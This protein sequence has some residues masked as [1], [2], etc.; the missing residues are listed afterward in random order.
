MTELTVKENMVASVHYTGTLPDS[1]EV[2]DSSEGREP[3]SFLVGHKQMIPGFEEEIMGAKVGEK[4]EF[5]LSS[6]RAYGDRDENAVQ[7]I[8]REQFTQLEEE[9]KLEVGMQLVAQGQEGPM[10]FIISE[11]SDD[12]VTADFNHALAGQALK[13][14][15]EIV[16][17][18]EAT[19]D[20]QAH[21]HAH[22]AD[23]HHQH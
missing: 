14:N 3:L 5:T 16:D 15:V 4:K 21:G 13:F 9:A 17:L 1:G 20:E 12:M 2:F 19:D 8:A 22:G 23:G 6:E 11:L 18:R 7:Q 10:P